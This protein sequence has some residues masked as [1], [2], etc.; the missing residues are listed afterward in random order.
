MAADA[1]AFL[2]RGFHINFGVLPMPPPPS[3][4]ERANGGVGGGDPSDCVLVVG[5]GTAGLAVLRALHQAG[6]KAVAFE[7]RDRLG[8]RVHTVS[9]QN[10]LYGNAAVRAPHT[11]PRP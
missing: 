9:L 5:A 11:A 8:G 1:Y 7:A 6:V 4:T 2:A 10:Q 3:V